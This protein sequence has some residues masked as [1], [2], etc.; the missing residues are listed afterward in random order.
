MIP[1]QE[2]VKK[3]VAF[4]R[5][6]LE[7]NRTGDILLEEVEPATFGGKEAWEITLSLPDPRL[8]FVLGAQRQYKTF[9][10]DGETGQVLSMKI[11]QLSTAT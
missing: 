5:E 9:T 1:V 2:A 10:V 8:S 11:R 3:A 6:V 7:A 4:A